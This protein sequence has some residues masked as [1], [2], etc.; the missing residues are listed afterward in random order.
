VFL[1]DLADPD[2]AYLDALYRGRG[3]AEKRIC[4]AK[5]TGLAN[6]PSHTF[7]INAACLSVVFI[8]Q[9]LLAWTKLLCLDGELARAEP[10]RLRYFLLHTAGVVVRSGRRSRLRL[11]QSA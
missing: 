2:I 1:T 6:L 10:K 4:D 8:A 7:A 3:R 11:A 9:D 5:D